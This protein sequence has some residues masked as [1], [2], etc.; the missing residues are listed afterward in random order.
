MRVGGSAVGK[1]AVP[2]AIGLLA[3]SQLLSAAEFTPEQ[4]KWL[5][6]DSLEAPGSRVNEGELSFLP[7]PR[8]ETIPYSKNVI[9]IHPDSIDPDSIDA[10]SI[11]AGWIS[12]KQCHH[13]LDS[14]PRLEI[15]YRYKHIRDLRIVE[16]R[17]IGDVRLVGQTVEMTDIERENRVCIEAEVQNLYSDDGWYFRLVNGPYHRQFLDGYYPYHVSLHI[18]YP[19]ERLETVRTTPREQTGFDIDYQ[20]GR[21]DIHA[22]FEGRLMIE[23]DFRKK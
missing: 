18:A 6:S 8:D 21:I 1:M 9:V 17:G 3:L 12:L 5:E 13:R 20:S 23:V 22:W 15:V 10:D 11:D 19:P 7:R 2:F 14:V 4:E 16:Q